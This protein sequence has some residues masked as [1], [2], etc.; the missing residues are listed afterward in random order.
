[1]FDNFLYEKH[2]RGSKL[3]IR[4][5]RLL[6]KCKQIKD[7]KSTHLK[8]DILNSVINNEKYVY[9]N[10]K[11]NMRKRKHSD[12]RSVNNIGGCKY[13]VK[14][15]RTIF[16]TKKLSC[17]EK[18]IFKELDYIDFLENNK[19]IS[20]KLYKKI[21][22]KKFS[23][24]IAAP[25]ILFLLLLVSMILDFFGFKGIMRGLYYVL[26]I[27]SKGWYQKFHAYLEKSSLGPLLKSMNKIPWK[28]G[29]TVGENGKGFH[30]YVEGFFG[31][32]IYFLPFLILGVTVI[33]YII[34]YHKKVKKYQKIKFG[35]R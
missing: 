33:L 9:I 32:I 24:R 17:I 26:K 34:I 19:T 3:D 35:K 5:Y 13:A 30:A 14:N 4:T 21:I 22:L 18:K 12:G 10:E 2:I 28:P 31:Y 20:D 29:E 8:E 27:I 11:G 25:L 1:M 15:K 7:M 23:L 16:D 6:E